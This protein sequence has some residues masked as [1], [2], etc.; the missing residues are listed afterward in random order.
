MCPGCAHGQ[1]CGQRERRSGQDTN[2]PKNQREWLRQNPN[3][4]NKKMDQHTH[5]CTD[6]PEQRRKRHNLGMIFDRDVHET[7][8][9][10]PKL[11][12]TTAWFLDETQPRWSPTSDSDL[13]SIQ[14]S[15]IY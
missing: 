10:R 6:Q 14:S 5:H 2:N 8:L 3:R 15:S 11:I 7:A 1:E 12:A 4:K 9:T 13:C